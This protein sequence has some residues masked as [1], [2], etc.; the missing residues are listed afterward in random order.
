MIINN[1]KQNNKKY[2]I[3]LADP[4]WQQSKGNKKSVRPNS[5]GT[6]LD[7][8]T[9]DLV[10]IKKI[11]A[12]VQTK[13]KHNFFVWTIDKYLFQAERIMKELGYSL[14]ARF[15][16]D[17]QNGIPVAFTVRYSH[18][19]LLWFYKKGNILMPLEN[20]RGKQMTVFSEPST[21]HSKK[22]TISYEII[23]RLF[24]DVPRLELFARN[25]REGWD[26]FGNEL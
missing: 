8:D 1:L 17:K 16:W 26:S 21:K 23:E 15:I 4:P 13:E 10:E 24:G 7:Y 9:L 25:V 19:Y 14:H 20:Q 2:S 12:Q 3:I 22:P 18:E 6:C 5:S 11:L